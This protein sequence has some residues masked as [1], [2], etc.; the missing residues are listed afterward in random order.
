MHHPRLACANLSADLGSVVDGLLRS[1]IAE[2]SFIE[3]Y[4]YVQLLLTS[5]LTY[6]R[7]HAREKR[8]L[9]MA[10]IL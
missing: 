2:P 10:T 5:L 3:L 9:H 4:V 8:L 6:Y 1:S 7:K